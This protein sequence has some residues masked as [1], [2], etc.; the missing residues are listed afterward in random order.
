M[1]SICS[2]NND[3]K[4]LSLNIEIPSRQTSQTL[5]IWTCTY[6][7]QVRD[8]TD[9]FV[10]STVCDSFVIE[11]FQND[12]EYQKLAQHLAKKCVKTPEDGFQKVRR[13]EVNAFLWDSGP[14]IYRILSDVK[15]QEQCQLVI[16]EVV[17]NTGGNQPS[18]YQAA[19]V[20]LLPNNT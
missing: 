18:N 13:S 7:Y 15:E 3:D 8:P 10:I 16:S 5:C 20:V 6:H 11:K 14:S 12:D 9:E 19:E 4:S 2:E 1:T 17:S